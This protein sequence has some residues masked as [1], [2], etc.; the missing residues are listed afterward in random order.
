M[1]VRNILYAGLLFQHVADTVDGR[2]HVKNKKEDKT[3]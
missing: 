1:G 2:Y 3:S